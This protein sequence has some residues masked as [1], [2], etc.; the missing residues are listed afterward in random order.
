MTRGYWDYSSQMCPRVPNIIL[1]Y[2]LLSTTVLEGEN[3]MT[4][5]RST[6]HRIDV[7]KAKIVATILISPIW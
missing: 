2:G 6:I 3:L 1:Q 5:L 4:V 7:A